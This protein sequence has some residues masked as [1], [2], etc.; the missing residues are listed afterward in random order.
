MSNMKRILGEISPKLTEKS[1]GKNISS[2]RRVETK[3]CTA[4]FRF[5]HDGLLETSER[6]SPLL[7]NKNCSL[8]LV[9]TSISITTGE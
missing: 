8:N 1:G 2:Q 5:L 6:L 9:H 3:M 4:M 7:K